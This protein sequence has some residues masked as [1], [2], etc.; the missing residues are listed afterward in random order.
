M[1]L[2]CRLVG[3]RRVDFDNAQEFDRLYIDVSRYK[4]LILE[5]V[6]PSTSFQGGYYICR[7]QGEKIF[8]SNF[9]QFKE[10]IGFSEF[11]DS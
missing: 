10:V 3:D 1:G 7:F 8:Q 4:K 6:S 2:H 11:P 5:G 9:V